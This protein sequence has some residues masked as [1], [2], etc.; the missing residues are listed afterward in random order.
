MADKGE[1]IHQ[2]KLNAQRFEVNGQGN[3]IFIVG[4]IDIDHRAMNLA[5]E[6]IRSP[7]VNVEQLV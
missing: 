3:P 1:M 6:S 7:T 5:V 4:D 2:N